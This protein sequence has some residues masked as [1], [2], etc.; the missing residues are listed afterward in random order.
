MVQPWESSL[1]FRLCFQVNVSCLG[2]AAIHFQTWPLPFWCSFNLQPVSLML[3]LSSRMSNWIE[4]K[5]K[6]F[7]KSEKALC[8]DLPT[9]L[10]RVLWIKTVLIVAYNCILYWSLQCLNLIGLRHSCGQS[11]ICVTGCSH[12]ATT[13]LCVGSGGVIG[14]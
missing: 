6:T 13:S 8:A 14:N 2:L 11:V 9:L 7:S 10:F 3:S 12:E 5:G 4:M 1:I